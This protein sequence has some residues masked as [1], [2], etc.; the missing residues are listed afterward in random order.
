MPADSR[1]FRSAADWIVKNRQSELKFLEPNAL[2][3][4]TDR[5]GRSAHY[6]ACGAKKLG[7]LIRFRVPS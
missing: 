6:L 5:S 2:I 3:V 1:F 4:T 7:T